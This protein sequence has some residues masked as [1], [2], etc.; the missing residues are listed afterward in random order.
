MSKYY[1]Q[2]D[3]SNVICPYCKSEYQ[4]ECEDYDESPSEQECEECRKKYM[5]YQSYN[6]DHHADP[7]CEING[8]EHKYSMHT[9]G[10]G[11]EHAFCD[12]C[13]KCK[14]STEEEIQQAIK[15]LKAAS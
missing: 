3:S 2:I 15:E 4:P 10:N 1:D 14:P 5:L 12:E 11:K 9:L 6:V 8:Q 13:G 7:D